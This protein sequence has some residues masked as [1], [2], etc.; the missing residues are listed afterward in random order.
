MQLNNSTRKIEQ[1]IYPMV[2]NHETI[3]Q[4]SKPEVKLIGRVVKSVR[5]IQEWNRNHKRTGEHLNFECHSICI[6]LA[7]FTPNL[8]VVHGCYCGIRQYWRKGKLKNWKLVTNDHSW[9]KTPH[10]NIIDPHPVGIVAS[11]PLV[12]IGLGKDSPYGSGL[13]V[14][15]HI[16]KKKY[17]SRKV[18]KQT[19]ALRAFLAKNPA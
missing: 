15:G 2:Y 19:K 13:Y 4:I 18:R 17:T 14:R 12:V 11:D 10:G 9:L 16:Q 5:T 3:S 7:S 1:R 8:K 6:A